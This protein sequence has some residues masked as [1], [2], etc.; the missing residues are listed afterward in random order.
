MRGIKV[1]GIID[2]RKGVT[3]TLMSAVL[4]T[5]V[6]VALSACDTVAG[7][8]QDISAGGHA[9]TRSADE[10]KANAP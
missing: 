3:T 5:G 6:A 2:W 1:R 9:L 10:T 4:L 7:A 8:G